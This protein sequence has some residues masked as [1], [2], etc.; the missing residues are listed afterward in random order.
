M[1]TAIGKPTR[2]G[3]PNKSSTILC[4]IK[5]IISLKNGIYIC[6]RIQPSIKPPKHSCSKK[7]KGQ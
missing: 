2:S 4:N 6:N 3:I 7:R 1:Y 5:N